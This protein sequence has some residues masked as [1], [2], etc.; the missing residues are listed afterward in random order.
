MYD[1]CM[2]EGQVPIAAVFWAVDADIEATLT[3]GNRD[4]RKIS[5][6]RVFCRGNPPVVA[7]IRQT[8][9]AI[10]SLTM[11][12]PKI[13][14]QSEPKIPEQSESKLSEPKLSEE[15]A[16][17]REP[18]LLE[19]GTLWE[20]T[21]E[22]TEFARECGALL[23]IATECEFVEENGIRFL[24]RVLANLARKDEAKKKQDRKKAETG[25]DF[26]PFLPYEEDL[27][28]ADIS[29][30]HLCLLNKFNVVDHHLLIVT[31]DFEEQENWLTLADF[32]AML[33]CMAEFDGLAFYNGGAIAGASQRHKHLQLVPL[34]LVPSGAK[35]P[36]EPLIAAAE[37]EDSI[38]RM[39]GF[40]FV[41]AL[42]RLDPTWT[43]SPASGARETMELYSRLLQSVGLRSQEQLEQ[44]DNNR[45]TGAYN[46]LATREWMLVIP[47][48]QE[49]FE[50][51]SIN[52]LGF[53]GALLVRNQDQLKIIQDCGAI[54]ALTKVA[55]CN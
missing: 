44:A 19:P 5:I 16:T 50:S 33:A 28:V 40:P 31:R 14:E 11:S 54:A 37:F 20:R 4:L 23:S 38:G 53:A 35:T 2:T 49:F 17:E 34:P 6:E 8:R 43:R 29:Q 45:Q 32:E 18:L 12:E 24:V 25:K 52:S 36:I 55:K 42:A 30:T 48:S 27:F 9:I 51:I 21:L 10:A 22:K 13:P 15:Q 39:P 1:L 47:R 41:H 26:N 3:E 7:P 46:F